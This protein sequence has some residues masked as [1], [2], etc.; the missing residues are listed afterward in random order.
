MRDF[1][2]SE[3]IYFLTNNDWSNNSTKEKA[4][5]IFTTICVVWNYLVGG[6]EWEALIYNSYYGSNLKDKVDYE[7]YC[8]YI[9]KITEL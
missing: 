4:R 5:A 1:L 7:E 2:E 3:L 6:G 8:N 9:T